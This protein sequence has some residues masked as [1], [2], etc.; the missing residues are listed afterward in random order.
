MTDFAQ[1]LASAKEQAPIALPAPECYQDFESAL[2]EKPKT[3]I[4]GLLDSSSRMI[5]GGGSKTYKT[6][7]MSDCALSIACSIPW[8]GFQCF[9]FGVL[10]VN[11]EL[12][13]FY[14]QARFKAI[15]TAKRI[16]KAP[17]NLYIWNLRG[18]D[19]SRNDFKRELLSFVAERGVMVVFIDPFYRLLGESD[20]RVSAELMPILMMFEELNRLTEVAIICA[21]HFTKGNQAAKDP[22]DR[23]SG[24]GSINRH[25]DSLLTLTK[26]QQDGAFTVDVVTRD[27]A[28]L[29]P[30]VVK[31]QYPLLVSDSRLDPGQIKKPAGRGVQYSAKDVLEVLRTVDDELPSVKEVF[32]LIKCETGM[33]ERTFYSLWKALQTSGEIF[34]SKL[35][36]NWNCK[37]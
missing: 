9:T 20:E 30:F 21:A 14:A 35:S 37:N 26:H 15:R 5:F 36:G 13:R 10:Y 16:A 1:M 11:F 12:K 32:E 24:G 19:V 27:F 29:L 4:E 17:Q 25:P 31:W 22:L 6:W 3:I 34:K 28:P 7:A 33:S 23:I 18:F 2:V 8:W